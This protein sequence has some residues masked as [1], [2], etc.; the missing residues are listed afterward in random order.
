MAAVGA[1]AAVRRDEARDEL[2][3]MTPGSYTGH[4]AKLAKEI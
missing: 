3:A 1:A 4:A 2:M